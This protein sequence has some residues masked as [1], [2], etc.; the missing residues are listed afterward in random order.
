M[1]IKLPGWLVVIV[2]QVPSIFMQLASVG[3]KE[4][5]REGD[6][7]VVRTLGAGEEVTAERPDRVLA[8]GAPPHPSILLPSK[9]GTT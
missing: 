4:Y 9:K 1:R 8:E 7:E 5:G 6:V 2:N 3:E